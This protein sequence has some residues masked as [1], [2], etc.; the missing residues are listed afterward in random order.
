MLMNTPVTPL[1]RRVPSSAVSA[2][3]HLDQLMQDYLVWSAEAL[4]V[5]VALYEAVDS[6][7]GAPAEAGHFAARIGS[8]EDRLSVVLTQ[9]GSRAVPAPTKSLAAFG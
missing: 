2:S 8:W 9:L 5:L 3:D 1:T 6:G 4:D 7:G